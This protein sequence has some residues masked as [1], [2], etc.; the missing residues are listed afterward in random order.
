MDETYYQSETL[1]ALSRVP[2]RRIP[3]YLTESQRSKQGL[4]DPT[5]QV[6]PVEASTEGNDGTLKRRGKKGA[7]VK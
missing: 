7:T 4:A 5:A 1:S 2:C 6:E 3:S